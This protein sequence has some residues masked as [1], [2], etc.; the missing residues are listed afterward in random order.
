MSQVNKGTHE[1]YLTSVGKGVILQRAVFGTQRVGEF[2]NLYFFL[3]SQGS[4]KIQ[5]FH[6]P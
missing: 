5:Y 2:C 1:F 4:G 6:Q 3:G